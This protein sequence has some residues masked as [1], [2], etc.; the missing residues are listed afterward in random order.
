MFLCLMF[1][2]CLG[3]FLEAIP[4]LILS[5][6]I[7]LWRIARIFLYFFPYSDR[8]IWD[9]SVGCTPRPTCMQIFKSHF[10]EAD[11]SIVYCSMDMVSIGGIEQYHWFLE[12]GIITCLG[13]KCHTHKSLYQSA[14]ITSPWLFF[15]WFLVRSNSFKWIAGEGRKRYCNVKLM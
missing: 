9:F 10:C 5:A 13:R 8:Q 15:W 11:A 14:Y 1:S 12:G 3:L 7:Q 6:A 4:T 2:A